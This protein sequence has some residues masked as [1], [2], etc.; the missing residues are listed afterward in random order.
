[1]FHFRIFP[2]T[3]L[4]IEHIVMLLVFDLDICSYT[5]KYVILVRAEAV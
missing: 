3:A 1:M 2:N 5:V 4:I